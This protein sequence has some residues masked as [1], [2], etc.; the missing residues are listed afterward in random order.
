MKRAIGFCAAL[1]MTVGLTMAMPAAEAAASSQTVYA[2]AVSRTNPA[3]HWF[4]S[5]TTTNYDN[6]LNGYSAQSDSEVVA[7]ARALTACYNAGVTPTDCEIAVWVRNGYVA[8]AVDTSNNS[9]GTSWGSTA[10]S[11]KKAAVNL[12]GKYGGTAAACQQTEYTKGSYAGGPTS[13]GTSWGYFYN[14]KYPEAIV[15]AFSQLGTAGN[16]GSVSCA[17]NCLV[18]VQ[19]AYGQQ[20]GGWAPNGYADDA[21]DALNYLRGQ[22]PGYST[23]YIHSGVPG[24][25]DIGALVWFNA[26]AD[27]ENDGH[28]GIYLGNDQFISATDGGIWINSISAWS[29]ASAS[30][31]GWS[32]PPSSWLGAGSGGVG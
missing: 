9:W 19:L 13:S 22:D 30:Y 5:A 29:A 11:A 10:R 15:W 17:G 31:A 20:G 1:A 24:A 4:G 28:V 27:N 7:E 2:L 14:S 6:R 23:D 21:I 26:S 25:N 3:S 12:C 32:E 16:C 18:F 8:L